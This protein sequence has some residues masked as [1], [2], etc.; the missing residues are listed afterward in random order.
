MRSGAGTLQESDWEVLNALP[1]E[2]LDRVLR[3]VRGA[4]AELV[5]LRR[6]LEKRWVLVGVCP[7]C[8][9]DV[10]GRKG[11]VYCSPAHRQ[12]AYAKRRAG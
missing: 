7:V 6:Q 2:D 5:E 11:K 10:W 4:E 12:A 3:L 8:D 9:G 1:D